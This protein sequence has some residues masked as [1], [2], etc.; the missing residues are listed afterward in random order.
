M[1]SPAWHFFAMGDLTPDDDAFI[2][3]IL[4]PDDDDDSDEDPIFGRAG[5]RPVAAPS[6][7]PVAQFPI[8]KRSPRSPSAGSSRRQ[9]SFARPGDVMK[10]SHVFL[11]GTH[12]KDGITIDEDNPSFCT[13]LFCISCDHPVLRF[14]DR[15]WSGATDYLFL[16][17]NYPDT[18]AANLLRA[19]RWCAFCCQCTF[20]HEQKLRKMPPFS[21]NWVCRGHR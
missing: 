19:P 10:C 8:P 9:T 7:C 13:S 18:V 11:G 1:I 16:R 12:L 14:R 15:M 3:D 21:T 5:A 17:N 4:G 20:Q 2:R 6:R